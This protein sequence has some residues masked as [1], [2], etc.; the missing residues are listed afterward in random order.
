[1]DPNTVLKFDG[2]LIGAK[3][4][5]EEAEPVDRYR[6]IGGG[7]FNSDLMAMA[8]GMITTRTPQ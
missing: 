6:L 3:G 4:A 7:G 5:I 2:C 8:H 1:M